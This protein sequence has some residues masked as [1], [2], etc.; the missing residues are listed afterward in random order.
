MDNTIKTNLCKG[1]RA[2]GIPSKQAHE[3]LNIVEKWLRENGVEWTNSRIKDL[4]QWYET[5]LAGQPTPAPWFKH[6]KDNMPLGIWNWVFKLKPA[7]ALGVLS[8]NTVF[9]EHKLSEAQKEKFLHGVAGNSSQN[10]EMLRTLLSEA[11]L[12][13]RVALLNFKS[14]PE[15]LFPTVWDM[16]G[17]IPIHNGRSMVRTEG[18]L[19]EALKALRESWNSVPQVTFDFLDRQGLLGYM[20]I[21]VVGNAYQLEL[22]RPHDTCVGRVSVLQ[23]PQLKARIIGNPNR[24]T[25]V[26]LEPLKQVYMTALRKLQSDVTH[27][28][29]SGVRWVQEKLRQEIELAGSD[30]T[31]ASDLLDVELCLELVD[32]V[33]GFGCIPGYQ[34]WA[35]YFVEVC[36]SPWFFRSLDCEI[37]WRQGDVLG[38][39]PS[40][41]LLSL[42]N[43]AA[44]Y[45]AYWLAVH[46][47]AIDERIRLSDVFRVVGDDI[48]MR[49]EIEPYYTRIIEALGGEINRSKTLKSNRV[50]EFAGRIITSDSSYLKAIKYVEPSDNSFMSY[51]AQLGDQAKF[52]LRPHQRQ[53]YDLFKEVPGV[54]VKGPWMPDSYGIALGD[55]YEWYLEEVLPALQRAEPD[56]NLEDYSM[57]LLKAQLSL[58]EAGQNEDV[59]SDEPLFDDG[60]LPSQVTPTFKVGGDP[61][62]TDGKTFLDVLYEHV[63]SQDVTPFKDWIRTKRKTSQ[64]ST[65]E[66]WDGYTDSFAQS[67]S[68][69]PAEV[70]QSV[71]QHTRRIHEE[72]HES[73]EDASL[74]ADDP[75]IPLSAKC[76]VASR[77]R[78]TVSREDDDWCL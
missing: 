71:I 37:Q 62:L 1:L 23:Q 11:D 18:K 6:S 50:A 70:P 73:H 27:D 29:E 38:T 75:V 47:D 17:S 39:G 8:L 14:M 35:D 59:L 51:V 53:A 67:L 60:Y 19:G 16:N 34:D 32:T 9:Y 25:Q 78:E 44:A 65:E 57:T 46:N 2:C 21:D 12:P 54:V 49:S 69:S 40:F 63:R 42:T 55:R 13:H 45:C 10:P 74:R 28:Q 24:V 15:I 56:L 72:P 43:N 36:R 22:D 26:T 52:F 68:E 61:R 33:Y 30:L 4:R 64:P 5:A 66:I 48:V 58:D 20:P 3:I 7:K 31:S 41:G 76:P 77:E